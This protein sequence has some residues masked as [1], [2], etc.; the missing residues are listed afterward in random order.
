MIKIKIGKRME[1]PGAI[2]LVVR[3]DNKVLILKR[4][5]WIRWAPGK[6]AFPGGKLEA[7]ESPE[8]AAVRETKEET[9]LDVFNLTQVVAC[10]D[11]PVTAYYTRDYTGDVKIDWE[12]D[13][14]AWASH[15]ELQAQDLAPDVLEM[16]EWV[17]KNE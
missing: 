5:L 13:D 17:M 11:K 16:Y 12:H 9:E 7:D 10:L 14:W 8:D 6:W 4:P 15:D 1:K 2:V 3:D